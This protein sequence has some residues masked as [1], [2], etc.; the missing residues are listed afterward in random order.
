MDCT[1]RKGNFFFVGQVDA[2]GAGKIVS[3]VSC[4]SEIDAGRGGRVGKDFSLVF[5]FFFSCFLHCG[6]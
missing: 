2:V 6:S 4:F 1:E 5:W 3:V